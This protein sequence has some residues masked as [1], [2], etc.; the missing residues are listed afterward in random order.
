MLLG[1]LHHT[2]ASESTL[3][4]YY[5][6]LE[7]NEKHWVFDFIAQNPYDRETEIIY[8]FCLLHPST[9]KELCSEPDGWVLKQEMVDELGGGET[10]LRAYTLRM[11]QAKYKKET[12]CI[13]YDSAC[14]TGQFLAE[15]KRYFPQVHTIGQDLSESMVRFAREHGNVNEAVH[16]DA[17][18]WPLGNRQVDIAF[19][20]FLNSE[21]VKTEF[22]Q[23]L[24][25]KIAIRVKSNGIIVV[26]GHTPVL[27][28][29]S[30]FL[31][32]GSFELQ[33]CVGVIN[34]IETVLFQYY[35]LKVQ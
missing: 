30:D 8:P 1:I 33:Q 13:L 32:L 28:A 16:A 15:L 25:E 5:Y 14:S 9:H 17:K 19:I 7:L 26:F 22:A 27:L 24:F 18:L 11:L 21:V 4:V 10:H 23:M 3:R 20:R 31:R 34:D 35:V 6:P 12:S 2:H 29:S